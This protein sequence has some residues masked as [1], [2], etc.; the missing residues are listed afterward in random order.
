MLLEREREGC[1]I[2]WARTHVI[3]VDL[4][5]VS[6]E[7]TAIVGLFWMLYVGFGGSEG[8][9]RA[10][11]LVAKCDKVG[12]KHANYRRMAIIEQVREIWRSSCVGVN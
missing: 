8:V 12:G 7:N 10:A 1:V 5:G 4:E 2:T 3:S 6:V 11:Q 9:G